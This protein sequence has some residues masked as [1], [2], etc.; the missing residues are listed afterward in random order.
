MFGF[1]FPIVGSIAR[2]IDLGLGIS[3]ANLAAVQSTDPLLWIVDTAPFFLGLFTGI[4]G[5]RQEMLEKSNSNLVLAEQELRD[6]QASLEQRVEKRISETTT[7]NQKLAKRADQLKTIAEIARTVVHSRDINEL[8]PSL[9]GLISERFGY[10]HVGIFLLDDDHKFA[11]LQ[12]A[13]SEG[14]ARMLAR[15]HRLQ[16]GQQGIVG[17][18]TLHGTARIALDVDDEAIYFTNPELPETHSEVA[19][20]LKFGQEILGAL[21]IQ[22]TER[23]VFSQE[24]LDLLSILADQVSVAIQNARSLERAQRALR[25]AETASGQLTGQAWRG[26]SETIRTKGYRYDGIKPEPLKKTFK[27]DDTEEAVSVP[28]Q[29]RGQTIGRFKLKSPDAS[30]KWTEDEL[31]II[32]STADRVAIAMDGARLL[33]EAQKRAARETFLSEL[34]AKLGTSFQ[35]DSILR[36]TVEELG[37]VLDS[38]VTFQLVN[39][40]AHPTAKDEGDGSARRKKAG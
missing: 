34:A 24:D 5:Y 4:A 27:P 26:Y 38:K 40:S 22:S 8:L 39:P 13:N 15:G 31:A 2:V 1:V 16:V 7:A 10:Y 18:V 21:D 37:Q 36:D 14:G 9:A 20:P 33:D 6:I 3:L 32:E 11:L 12:A 19:L 30:R 25:E 23:N 35:M 28:V 17:Y 29:L